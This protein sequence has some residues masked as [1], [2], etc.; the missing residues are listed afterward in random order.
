MRVLA[1]DYG[2][3]R[4]G[5]AVSDVLELTANPLMVIERRGGDEEAVMAE[6][7][8]VVAAEE[9]EEVVV[10][11]PLN[12]D[13]SAG[14]AAGAAAAF[15]VALAGR[16]TVPVHTIDEHLTTVE[17]EASLRRD[18]QG[19]SRRARLRRR[20]VIDKLAAAVILRDYLNSRRR[21]G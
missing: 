17:A 20:R 2:E 9:V 1:V 11:V 4:V 19:G 10:G 6:I 14:P 5:L 12:P 18:E 7:G 15:A 3:K 16:L 8:R 21:N 13:G